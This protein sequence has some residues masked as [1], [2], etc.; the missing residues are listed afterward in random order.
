[1]IA[2]AS[3]QSGP[4]SN[5][6]VDIPHVGWFYCWFSPLL[7]GV[8]L[9]VLWFSPLLKNQHFCYCSIVHSNKVDNLSKQYYQYYYHHQVPPTSSR[10]AI[11]DRS[12]AVG[13]AHRL[14]LH[15]HYRCV[16]TIL[17]CFFIQVTL[18]LP[19]PLFP[20]ILPSSNNFWID[21][22]LI[23]CPKYWHFLF[24]IVGNNELVAFA[25][26]KTSSLV[27]CS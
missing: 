1:M 8:F 5:P 20:S 12:P 6:G 13:S 18:G 3:H 27:L 10:S 2:L 22:A 24:F 15:I 19:H 17:W 25:I 9:Q 4:S 23:K 14:F 21:L 11:M 7:W 16:P 26:F